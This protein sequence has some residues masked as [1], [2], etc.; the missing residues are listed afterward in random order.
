M[1]NT[2]S[3]T[4]KPLGLQLNGRADLEAST[5]KLLRSLAPLGADK[6]FMDADFDSDHESFMV[7]GVPAYSLATERGDYDLQHH[8]I[9]DTFER[10]D[11]EMLGIHTAVMAVLAYQFANSDERPGRK[12]SPV[13]VLELLKRT[14]LEPLYRLEYPDAKP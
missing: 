6:V 2:D 7:V 8:T 12:L 1:I 14:G 4:H 13:E 9:I 5:K 3:G 11:P 10:I